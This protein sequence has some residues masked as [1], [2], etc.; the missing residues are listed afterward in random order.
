LLVVVDAVVE[1]AVVEAFEL[2]VDGADEV[3]LVDAG[4][5][6][7]LDGEETEAELDVVGLTTA[8][9]AQEQTAAAEACTASTELPH[10]ERTQVIAAASIALD[11]ELLH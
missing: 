4:A 7:E 8:V 1:A 10:A 9:A 3:E 6:D 11:W 2:E 5:A